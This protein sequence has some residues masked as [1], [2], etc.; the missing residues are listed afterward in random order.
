MANGKTVGPGDGGKRSE[1]RGD[2]GPLEQQQQQGGQKVLR[3]GHD[4]SNTSQAYDP[5]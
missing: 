1:Q 3:N 2:N 4:G 5:Y